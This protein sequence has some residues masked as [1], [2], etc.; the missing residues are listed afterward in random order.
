MTPATDGPPRTFNRLLSF[1]PPIILENQPQQ[2]DL[3]RWLTRRTAVLGLLVV[4][5]VLRLVPLVQNRN[6]WIDE[7]M[8]ALNLVERTPAQLLEPLDW[9]QGAPP[10]FLILVKATISVLGTAEWSLR[11]IP[12]LSSVLGLLGFAWVANRWLRAPTAVAAILLYAVSPYLISYSAEC[13][14]YA[15]DAALTVGVLAAATT[16]LQSQGRF[17]NW[18]AL[19]GVGVLAVWLSHSIIF[20][21][22]GCAAALL[23]DSVYR[24]DR[25]RTVHCLVVVGCWLM[26]FGICFVGSL[27]HLEANRFLVNYWSGHFLPLAPWRLGTLAWLGEHL[28]SLVA[29]PGGLGGTEIKAGGIA[30]ALAALGLAGFARERWVAAVVLV[31]P[32]L[33][34]LL[35]S[36]LQKYPFAGRLLLFSVPL[37]ILTVARGADVAVSAL[38]PLQPHSAYLALGILGSATLLETYQGLETPP[39]QEQI[40]PVMEQLHKQWKPGDQIYVYY[41]AIPA[42]RFYGR[43]GRFPSGVILGTESREGRTSY[44]DELQR[45]L[46]KPRVWLLFSHRYQEEE[47]LI[48]AYAEGYGRCIQTI[49]TEG[50]AAFLFDLSESP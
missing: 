43:D 44:R 28:F 2:A 50:A 27:R 34:A 30:V 16:L 15:S 35:A 14:Q 39:R 38:R 24:R 9:N 21:L 33:L 37:L 3:S 41:G 40:Q 6:L 31:A 5:T 20:V 23:I 10:G 22:G 46:G 8:L 7:A 26:S 48:R 4:G 32:L 36:G 49:Q 19:T 42:F 25:A 18:V 12:F 47:S 29:Y 1:N 11:L 13:K 45:F 17:H